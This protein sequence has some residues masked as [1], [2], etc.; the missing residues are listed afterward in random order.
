MRT[1]PGVRGLSGG[2]RARAQGLEP[3]ESLRDPGADMELLYREGGRG[4]LAAN[5]SEC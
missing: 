1:L 2:R 5:V 4:G 3:F